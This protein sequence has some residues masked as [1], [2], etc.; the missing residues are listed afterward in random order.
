MS[1]RATS[2]LKTLPAE[3]AEEMFE[4]DT[5][6][7]IPEFEDSADSLPFVLSGLEEREQELQQKKDSGQLSC[8]L[9]DPE[10]ENCSG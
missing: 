6:N 5:G 4:A 3:K 10:C 2:Y 9:D 8:S 1:G 7:T